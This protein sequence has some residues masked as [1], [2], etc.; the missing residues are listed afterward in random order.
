MELIE[1]IEWDENMKQNNIIGKIVAFTLSYMLLFS[2]SACGKKGVDIASTQID[3]GTEYISLAP[4][5]ASALPVVPTS[6]PNSTQIDLLPITASAGYPYTPTSLY[7]LDTQTGWVNCGLYL[8]KTEDE[9]QTWATITM[10]ESHYFIKMCFVDENNG[11][12]FDNVGG[13]YTMCALLCT[14]DG[15]AHWTT[16]MKAAYGSDDMR[17]FDSENGII[18][19]NKR[20]FRTMDRGQT[21]ADVTPSDLDFI[22]GQMSFL[23]G[24]NGWVCG[25]VPISGDDNIVRKA[26]IYRTNDGGKTWMEQWSAK[27][28]ENLNGITYALD[29]VNETDGWLILGVD[30]ISGYLYRTTDGGDSFQIDNDF[31]AIGHP[32]LT[33]MSFIGDAIGWLSYRTN[34][35]GHPGGL[36]RITSDGAVI[37]TISDEYNYSSFF[38]VTF[39]SLEVGFAIGTNGP[40]DDYYGFMIGTIDGGKTWQHIALPEPDAE[41]MSTP[42][43]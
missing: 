31:I 19:F 10:D 3:V 6:A 34:A 30:G 17:F 26:T 33:G 24:E 23:D 11:W 25:W 8:F 39:P 43:S 1:I 7:F 32:L 15:G 14:I 18:L 22:L 40:P 37:S 38:A 42:L 2:L 27:D 4:T 29:F 28:Y 21:W 35:M 36:S 41:L 5:A 20:L 16:I 13:D 12:A 9:G